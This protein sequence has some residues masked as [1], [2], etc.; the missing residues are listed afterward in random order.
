MTSYSVLPTTTSAKTATGA[1]SAAIPNSLRSQTI[2]LSVPSSARRRSWPKMKKTSS[3][4]LISVSMEDPKKDTK[5]S[6]TINRKKR[7]GDVRATC[8]RCVAHLLRT[9][10]E[11]IFLFN[12]FRN[13]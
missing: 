2:S 10:R 7:P 5:S 8:V 11:R 6:V 3:L 12:K 13:A 9:Y 1:T 4:H